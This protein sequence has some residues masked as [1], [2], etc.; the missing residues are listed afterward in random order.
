[1][2]TFWYRYRPF[3]RAGIQEMVT[4]RVNFFLYR[5]G[6]VI[7]AFVAFYLW[8]AVFDSSANPVLNHFSL[9]DM[10]SYIIV[11]F[12]TNLLTKSDSSFMIGDEVKDGSIVMRL[13][14]PVHFA[15][16]Y[17]FTELGF[18]CMVFLSVGF[19]FLLGMSLWQIWQ[20][21]TFLQVLLRLVIYL[22]SLLLAYLM[23][24]YFNICFG[25]TAFV[26]KNL[27]GSNLL[28]NSI[29]AFLSGSL[30]PLAFFPTIVAKILSILPFS[31][32]VYAPVMIFIG[33]YNLQET[34]FALGLQVF[35]LL[36]FV[37]LSQLVWKAVQG[38]LTVQGG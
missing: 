18:K 29:V 14:R 11:G 26:F 17:L 27:W 31:S 35:W 37:G 30:I 2:K 21:Q 34:F 23:N 9:A 3:V 28:K 38:H 32:L 5:L 10:T 4:Y 22:F 20:G 1:M 8:K 12:L 36:F 15:I 19:P 7:G 16:S 33:K 25:F 13:L 24:F 6:D